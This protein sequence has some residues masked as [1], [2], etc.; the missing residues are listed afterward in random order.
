VEPALGD[1]E[2]PR[3]REGE[4]RMTFL[5]EA[6]AFIFDAES[7]A[8]PR[9]I[10]MRLLQHLGITGLSILITAVIAVP[11]GLLIGHTGR[12]R[13][14]VIGFTGAARAL[15]TFGVLIL[16]VLIGINFG[17]GLSLGPVIAVLVIL[18]VP[19]L[20]AGTYSGVEAVD[21]QTIDAARAQGMTEWQIL[22]RVE[23]PLALPLLVGGLRSAT[24]QVVATATIA[25]YVAQGGLGRFIIEGVQLRDYERAVIGALLL[26]A[27]ALLLD[28]LLA[29]TQ[30]LVTPR[31]VSRGQTRIGAS[32][33]T[34]STGSTARRPSRS[35]DATRTPVTE[36]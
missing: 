3:P 12:G 16:F 26:A 10:G 21:R 23:L 20:L 2:S 13:A 11:F 9:G 15:P 36:G 31:G 27:L 35:L 33:T 5:L 24:L 30:R 25:A 22:K 19:P 18:A 7:W 32:R 8:G 4:D 17:F 14:F 6:L 34:G 28:G 1:P 29:V